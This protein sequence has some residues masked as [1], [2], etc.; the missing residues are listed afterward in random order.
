MEDFSIY[1]ILEFIKGKIASLFCSQ[2][3]PFCHEK[4]SCDPIEFIKERNMLKC[5]HCQR[6]LE[7]VKKYK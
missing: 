3:C 5:S 4:T 6:Y 7:A 2:E 1:G